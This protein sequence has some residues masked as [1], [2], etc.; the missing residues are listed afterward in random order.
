MENI[1]EFVCSYHLSKTWKA[2]MENIYEFVCSY[3]L[4]KIWQ[5]TKT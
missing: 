1:Y 3:R 5:V 2:I 4:G